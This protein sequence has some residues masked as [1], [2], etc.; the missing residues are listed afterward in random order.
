[1]LKSIYEHRLFNA[2]PH[3]G[4][5]LFPEGGRVV[6]LDF[7]CVKEISEPM[8]AMMRRYFRA[9]V[10]ATRTDSRA[11][12]AEFDR[13][14]S[15]AFRLDPGGELYG[16]YREFILYCLRPYLKDEPFQFTTDYTGETVGMALRGVKDA[17]FSKGAL[18][19]IPDLPEVRPEFTLLSRLQWGFYSVMTMLGARGNWHRM[20]PPELR[21]A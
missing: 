16:L 18:P 12:W 6:F 3:P 1:M 11:D 20:L 21:G 19:R 13:A 17:V 14:I 15:E 2:D 4:N 7:G 5:Y 10:A 8:L 9:A